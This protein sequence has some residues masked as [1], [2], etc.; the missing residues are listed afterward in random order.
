MTFR[1]AL[2]KIQTRTECNHVET[3]GEPCD[4]KSFGWW[5]CGCSIMTDKELIAKFETADACRN[6]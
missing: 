6:T 2:T 4:K 5:T 1:E 3:V